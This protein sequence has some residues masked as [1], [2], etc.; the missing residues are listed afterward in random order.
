MT[1]PGHFWICFWLFLILVF[2][3]S[4]ATKQLKDINASIARIEAKMGHAQ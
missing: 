1:H 4:D 3:D 2:G